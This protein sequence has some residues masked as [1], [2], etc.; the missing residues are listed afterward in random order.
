VVGAV[1]LLHLLDVRTTVVRK[2]TH[3]KDL[4]VPC[5]KQTAAAEK[6]PR[7]LPA[8]RMWF[9]PRRSFPFF[10]GGRKVHAAPAVLPSPDHP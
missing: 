7:P 1:L 6:M 3:E 4:G 5:A 8:D 10:A 9:A 2:Y